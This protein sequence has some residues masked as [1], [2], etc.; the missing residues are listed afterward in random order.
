MTSLRTTMAACLLGTSLT[1]CGAASFLD[2]TRGVTVSGYALDES[3]IPLAN[4]TLTL[5][6]SETKTCDVVAPFTNVTTDKTG[7]Y[8]QQVDAQQTYK[9]T[10]DAK[11]CIRVSLAMG[12]SGARSTADFLVSDNYVRVPDLQRWSGSL[13][14][15]E[16]ADGLQLT[17]AGLPEGRAVNKV[18][19]TVQVGSGSGT[20][21]SV[22]DATSPLQLSNAV[23]ESFE[24]LAVRASTSIVEEQFTLGFWSD[25]EAVQR[26]PGPPSV[27][28]GSP[29]AYTNSPTT[30]TLTDGKL[31]GVALSKPDKVTITFSAPKALTQVLLRGFSFTGSGELQGQVNGT[32][33]QLG[34]FEPAQ[35]N[36]PRYLEISK[37]SASYQA[38]Q[39]VKKTG[40]ST[41]EI[42]RL[43]EVS[44]F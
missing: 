10:D 26:V 44:A 40:A 42:T 22:S 21:W 29:C 15:T 4:T 33:V 16:R 39:L 43:D 5:S 17:F 13:L 32:W 41:F 3:G 9:N 14:L 34:T 18:P 7:F 23:F 11:R 31:E 38:L 35:V 1:H 25:A 28:R 36:V 30:C 24:E 19:Y 2:P 20:V 12:E 37:A 6:R 8:S 27:I